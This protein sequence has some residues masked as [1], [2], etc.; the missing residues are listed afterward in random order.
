MIDNPNKNKQT[1]KNAEIEMWNA[2]SRVGPYVR[3]EP[4]TMG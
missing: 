1:V 3:K 2:E 4:L